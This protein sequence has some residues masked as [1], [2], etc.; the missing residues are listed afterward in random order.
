M[1]MRGGRFPSLIS[2]KVKPLIGGV[3]LHTSTLPSSMKILT[4]GEIYYENK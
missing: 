4:K 2:L 3:F 1:W